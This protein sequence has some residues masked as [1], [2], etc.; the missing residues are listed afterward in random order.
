[1]NRMRR[2]AV[3]PLC[4]IAS[5]AL[6]Y[7][8]AWI[9]Q[10]AHNAPPRAARIDG[11]RSLAARKR[12]DDVVVVNTH[13]PCESAFHLG[14]ELL[15]EALAAV[16]CDTNKHYSALHLGQQGEG[17]CVTN[18]V[19]VTGTTRRVALP[20]TS[21]TAVDVVGPAPAVEPPHRHRRQIHHTL[22]TWKS[23]LREDSA[24][25]TS[26]KFTATRLCFGGENAKS[27]NHGTSDHQV[28]W[29][30]PRTVFSAGNAH[31][32]RVVS[33]HT[34]ESSPHTPHALCGRHRVLAACA[35]KGP[36]DSHRACQSPHVVPPCRRP[37]PATRN[38]GSGSRHG[39]G[40]CTT[41]TQRWACPSH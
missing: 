5:M 4:R 22:R 3:L 8:H 6:P 17:L 30:P 15:H 9:R 7:N 16:C 11:R 39:C 10:C 36:T 23:C 2:F 27:Q 37:T 25:Q 29:H 14:L 40:L 41:C 35:C 32:C 33:R 26:H 34:Q 12:G 20:C 18:R 21:H 13:T 38:R 31:A 24:H 28:V 1:M 19:C